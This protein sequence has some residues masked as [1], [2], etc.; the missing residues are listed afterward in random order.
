MN[1]KKI[2]K[3]KKT[4]SVFFLTLKGQREHPAPP[5][6]KKPVQYHKNTA[7]P[8]LNQNS[9]D[10]TVQNS[11]SCPRNTREKCSHINALFD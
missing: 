10:A 5:K 8:L 9:G 7:A 3:D 6:K 11:M 2:T 1:S 4:Y